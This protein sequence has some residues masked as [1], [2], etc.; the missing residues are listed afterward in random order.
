MNKQASNRREFLKAVG[1]GATS[2]LLPGCGNIST[3][4]NRGSKK[5]PNVL[6]IFVDQL[7]ADA[8][9]VYGGRNIST[10]NIDRLAA[11]GARFTNG[12]ST[13]PVCTPFRG[14]VQTG[15][16]PSHSGLVINWVEAN[17][18]QRCIAHVFGEAGYD[19]GFIGKWHLSGGKRKMAGKFKPNR[20]AIKEWARKNPEREFTPPGPDR[21]GYE[22]WEAFNFHTD[23]NNFWYYRDEPK[24]LYTSRYE[25]DSET[26]LAI[27]FMKKHENS[28]KP[29]FLMVAPHPPHPPFTHKRCPKGYLE[30]IREDLFWS[31]NVPKDHKRRVNQLEAR[32]YFAMCRN[33]DYNIGRIMS[34]LEKSGMAEDTIVVF[35]SDHGEQHGSHNTIHKMMPYAESV[36]IPLIISRPGHIPAGVVSDDPYTPMDHMATL[37]SMCGLGV[38]DTCDGMDMSRAVSG[39][40]KVD[41]DAVL[42]MNHTSNWDYFQTGTRWP[43][44]RAVHTRQHTYVKWLTGEEEMYDNLADPAQMNNLA[45]EQKDLPRLRKMRSRLKDLLAESHDEFRPGTYYADWYDDERNLLRTALG[46]V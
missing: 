39:Q 5:R 28:D 29:F 16:Y 17:P 3:T 26:D 22:H 4:Q 44:W 24:K 2:L 14:M 18:N 27:N 32:I 37:S 10:P 15:R 12:L 20:Q 25:T 38:P 40:G 1:M 23:F 41:R 35:T 45:S 43:E 42:M 9:S 6:F 7:R 31:E 36:N 19:T 33:V 11:G 30:Q 34:Y 21:L 8:C 46:P 13:C